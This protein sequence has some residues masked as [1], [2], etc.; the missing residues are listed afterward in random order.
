MIQET[1]EID[2]QAVLIQAIKELNLK[3][4]ALKSRVEQLEAHEDSSNSR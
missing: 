3:V 4:E 1:T 2:I